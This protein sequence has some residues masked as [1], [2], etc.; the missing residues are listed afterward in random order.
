MTTPPATGGTTCAAC[1]DTSTA[2]NEAWDLFEQ[3]AAESFEVDITTCHPDQAQQITQRFEDIFG[4]RQY[5]C[6]TCK[7]YPQNTP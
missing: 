4:P 1:G 6:P 5:P 2:H 3:W 7:P